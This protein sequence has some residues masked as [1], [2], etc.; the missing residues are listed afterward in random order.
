MLYLASREE[1]GPF[2]IFSDKEIVRIFQNAQRM[3]V[4]PNNVP[5]IDFYQYEEIDLAI[6]GITATVPKH[7]KYLFWVH[8]KLARELLPR[9]K[10]MQLS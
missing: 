4:R 9:E 7:G 5:G 2:V 8:E 10:M 6:D 3:S 1:A